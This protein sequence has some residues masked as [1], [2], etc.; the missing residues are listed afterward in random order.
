AT[1]LIHTI[2]IAV[3]HIHDSGVVYR[4][5]RPENLLFRNPEEGAPVV[6]ADFGLSRMVEEAPHLD[7]ELEIYGSRP[8]MAPEILLEAGHSQPVDIWAAGVLTFFIIAGCT[9]FDRDTRE[10]QREAIIAGEYKIALEGKWD[11]LSV[12]A[13]DFIG[14]CLTIDPNRR[15]VVREV[16]THTWLVPPTPRFVLARSPPTSLLE[17]HLP[18]FQRIFNLKQKCRTYHNCCTSWLTDNVGHILGLTIKVLNRMH[19][20]GSSTSCHAAGYRLR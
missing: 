17:R 3:R 11:T 20:C 5:L 4:D 10:L 12:N 9:P 14:M 1:D 16:L 15:P 6:I 8:Y 2:L 13:R 18:A 7:G 19:T